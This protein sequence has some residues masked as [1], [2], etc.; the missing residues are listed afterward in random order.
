LNDR[1]Y[2]I[3]TVAATAATFDV[4]D[5]SIPVRPTFAARHAV[6]AFLAG[7]VVVATLVAAPVAEAQATLAPS[8][9]IAGPGP[10]MSLG[11]IEVARDGTGGV[12]FLANAGGVEHVFVS[13]LIGGAFQSPEQLDGGLA[14]ASSQ[15]VI[16]GS[17]G[18]VLQVAYMN[19]GNLYVTGTTSTTASWSAPQV[20]AA[21]AANPTISMNTYGESYL[22]FTETVGGGFDVDVDY[23]NGSTWAPA[24]PQ[25]VNATSGD[26]AG[27]GAGR[28][29]IATAGD[30]VAIVAWGENG[31]VYS[32]RVWGTGTSVELEQLDPS[33]ISGWSEVAA[34]DPS[35]AVG[36]DS[37]Y[38]DI[39]FQEEV[40]SGAQTQSRVLLAR[41]VAEDTKP[42]VGVDDLSTPGSASAD[43]PEVAMN[44]YGRG[45]VTS[46]TEG[47]DESVATTIGTNGVPGS[48]SL[49]GSGVVAP[50]AFPASESGLG[51][52]DA[53]PAVAGLTSTLIAW[54][55]SS[56]GPGS[57]IVVRYAQDGTDLAVAQAVSAGGS[58]AALGLAAAGDVNGDAAVAWVQGSGSLETIDAA[59]FYQPPGPATTAASLA[60]TRN[61]HPTLSWTP[62][63][64]VWGPLTYTVTLD[65][66]VLGRT[67]GASLPVPQTL[68]DGPHVWQV[69]VTNPAG[70]TATSSRSTVFVD[71]QP[72][73]LR[74]VLTGTARVRQV[75]TLEVAATD[76]PNPSEPGSV[77]SGIANVAVKWSLRGASTNATKL[78]SLTHV[79]TSPGLTRITVTATDN[80]GNV[81]TIARFLR[82]L[83]AA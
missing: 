48:T 77:A 6:L 62:S 67:T 66:S 54:Q 43:Q 15:P 17:N 1:G 51:A 37:S 22:A 2:P 27:T 5:G 65:G 40:A 16:T 34:G 26:D 81:A 39:A 13:R 68:I 10:G 53:V 8:E 7:S 12:V 83:P 63:R 44:E 20:V 36:G 50:Y 79:F 72:P 28:P 21:A 31:H 42:A 18:G 76:P 32:R 59:Q 29:D 82:I 49:I 57:Q 24:S 64:A 56:V 4:L 45:F 3:R 30:G 55:Q 19:A 38:P 25:Q 78:S 70:L 71:T 46:A 14:S 41:L 9:A 35:V 69:A 60:Y 75:V 80:A 33:R 47:S 58:N 23:F 11:G 61:V 74:I 52:P 73:R